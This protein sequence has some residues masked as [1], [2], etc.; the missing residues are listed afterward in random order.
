MRGD[1]E[2]CH[3]GDLPVVQG[4]LRGEDPV[5][6]LTPTELHD[7]VF[8]MARSDITKPEQ[9]ENGRVGVVDATGQLGRPVQALL[10]Q[11]NVSATL[12]SLGS[13]QAI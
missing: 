10:K 2:F 3:T 12:V 9:L 13:F 5:L 1:W 8:V 7:G 6:I 11:W 4:V